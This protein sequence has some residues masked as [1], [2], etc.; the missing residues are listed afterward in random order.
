MLTG[1]LSLL[2][3]AYLAR[4]LMSGGPRRSLP[5]EW[6]R[7]TEQE[8]ARL[9]EDVDRLSGSVDRLLEE[10][11]FLL[12]LLGPAERQGLRG[13]AAPYRQVPD[14]TDPPPPEI[15]QP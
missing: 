4:M 7:R 13:S 14:G 12:S 11:T 5:P 9:R 1:V 2:L 15:G 8:I 3:V 10:Q 6:E